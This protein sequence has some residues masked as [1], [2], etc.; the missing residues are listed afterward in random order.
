MSKL[1][2]LDDV[3]IPDFSEELVADNTIPHVTHSAHTRDE[4]HTP[5]NVA[6]KYTLNLPKKVKDEA[7][8]KDK[9]YQQLCDLSG[10]DE[11]HLDEI[12]RCIYSAY[13]Q[14]V[15]DIIIP[16]DDVIQIRKS[17][18]LMPL[19]G[20][21]IR[22]SEVE[23]FIKKMYR[24]DAVRN[25]KGIDSEDIDATY[26]VTHGDGLIRLRTNVC[27]YR[28]PA[29]TQGLKITFRSLPSV[30]PSFDTLNTPQFIRDNCMPREGLILVSGET[31]SGKT[32]L[33]AAI[34]RALNEDEEYSR[35]IIANEHP[36]EFLLNSLTGPNPIYQH[37]IGKYDDFA[38]FEDGLS[39]ALRCAPEVIFSGES[40]NRETFLILPRIA[41]S[42]HMGITT[43]HAGSVPGTLTRIADEIGG[44][45]ES[46]IR[47]FIMHTHLIINQWLAPKV[48]GGV[49]PIQ[50]W[51]LLNHKVKEELLQM[52]Y[53]SDLPLA[54]KKCVEKYGRTFKSAA[55]EAL[56]EGA[57][58]KATYLL[59]INS[60]GGEEEVDG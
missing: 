10:L 15:S 16:S 45:Q 58:T 38:T 57:I 19:F 3:S 32:T 17:K 30:I 53:G 52:E 40:R 43:L 18:V 9:Q 24:E 26:D 31:G 33:C 46:T 20:R 7:I 25:L 11:D 22:A 37:A 28:S 48:G 44:N 2:N 13:G 59:A 27:T 21:T 55:K 49:V 60:H 1:L 54:V 4:T 41:E 39:N 50:E 35:I 14:S 42:G 51:L 6:N 47:K 5:N 56:N 23:S 12:L 29:G 8:Y 36:P 34:L